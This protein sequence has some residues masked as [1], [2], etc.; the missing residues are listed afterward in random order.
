MVAAQRGEHSRGFF[1][2]RPDIRSGSFR[3]I[4]VCGEEKDTAAKATQ[5]YAPKMHQPIARRSRESPSSVNCPRQPGAITC[6][7]RW[8]AP[9]LTVSVARS[10]FWVPYCLLESRSVPHTRGILK[11]GEAPIMG[12]AGVPPL[13]FSCQRRSP[14]LFPPTMRAPR[15]SHAPSAH[16]HHARMAIE[17]SDQ[18]HAPGPR[19]H[20]AGHAPRASRRAP[21]GRGWAKMW[22]WSR[23]MGRYRPSAWG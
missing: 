21:G 10:E 22:A 3:R 5:F 6:A 2:L 4:D 16:H 1:H 12:P 14:T 17:V 11:R 23:G 20:R 8:L 18:R 19:A 15:P 9:S 7:E 13:R